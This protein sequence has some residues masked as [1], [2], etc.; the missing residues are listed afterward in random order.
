MREEEGLDRAVTSECSTEGVGP[1]CIRSTPRGSLSLE[2][3]SIGA[4]KLL[5]SKR[6]SP[7]DQPHLWGLFLASPSLQSLREGSCWALS[8]FLGLMVNGHMIQ[9]TCD[10]GMAKPKE[11]LV[12][13]FLWHRVGR[14][15]LC[16]ESG[17]R[18]GC[19][20]FG[21]GGVAQLPLCIP[22][23]RHCGPGNGK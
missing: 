17:R 19:V 6:T 9:C 22:R 13:F 23:S 15:G 3:C 10:R 1:W 14:F 2:P 5:G 16:Q 18:L 8:I 21:G 11:S 7:L 4:E 12:S 20:G